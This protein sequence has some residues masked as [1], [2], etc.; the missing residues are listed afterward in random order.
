MRKWFALILIAALLILPGPAAA[1]QPI[2]FD[3]VE[4]QLWPEFDDPGMLVIYYIRVA[5][6]TTFPAEV[7]IRIPISAELVVVAIGPDFNSVSDQ[8]VQ[9]QVVPAGEW[10]AITFTATGPAVQLEFYDPIPRDGQTRNYTYSWPGDANVTAI[11]VTLQEPVGATNVR[12]DP[13]L[14]NL[15]VSNND[16]LRY[17]GKSF[18]GLNAGTTLNVSV[19]YDKADDSLSWQTLQVQAPADLGVNTS[20]AV[21]INTILPYVLGGLGIFLLVGGLMY[22]FQAG[23]G[24]GSRTRKRHARAQVVDAGAGDGEVYCHECGKRAQTGDRFCRTCGTRLRRE[25]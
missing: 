14:D 24:S 11:G 16:G 8:N 3:L 12:T 9:A 18:G 10:Q 5:E 20:P 21:D 13:P 4:V 22:Y 7:T 17:Y 15:G 2:D 19:T 1:Q 25:A 23:R 6:G